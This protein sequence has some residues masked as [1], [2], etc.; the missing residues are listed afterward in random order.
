MQSPQTDPPND[1][2]ER[3]IFWMIVAVLGLVADIILPIWWALFS[4][5]PIIV[6]AWW[7]AYRSDWF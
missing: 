3:K 1:A 2:M 6:F 4:T 5:I 7:V